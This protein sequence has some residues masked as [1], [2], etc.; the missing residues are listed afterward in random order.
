MPQAQGHQSRSEGYDRDPRVRDRVRQPEP[1]YDSKAAGKYSKPRAHDEYHDARTTGGR[2]E[3]R[4][5]D[6]NNPRAAG[7][8]KSVAT[9]MAGLRLDNPSSR[10]RQ[11]YGPSEEEVR[12]AMAVLNDLEK[13][14]KIRP[15]EVRIPDPRQW[16]V[17]SSLFF[18]PFACQEAFCSRDSVVP[19]ERLPAALDI[20][21]L[22]T[23][24]M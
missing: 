12:K 9:Q 16:Y 19:P 11:G 5:N 6:Y 18:S 3:S 23:G 22:V 2:G 24:I 20:G 4:H 8:S 15:F 1:Q 14:G 17:K 21:A 7:P 13:R 10:T